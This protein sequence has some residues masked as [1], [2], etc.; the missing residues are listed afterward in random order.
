MQLR[1]KSMTCLVIAPTLHFMQK[2]IILQ[3]NQSQLLNRKIFASKYGV[4][5]E[6][7]HILVLVSTGLIC[8]YLVLKL[9]YFLLKP[10][11]AFGI[12]FSTY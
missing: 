3:E 4:L 2:Q 6:W 11:T 12:Y 1:T 7:G 9:T 5:P 10:I 8:G